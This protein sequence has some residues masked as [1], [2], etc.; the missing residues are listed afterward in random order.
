MQLLRALCDVERVVGES[1]EVVYG[2]QVFADRAVELGVELVAGYMHEICAELVLIFIYDVLGVGDKS[3]ALVAEIIN[4]T[5]GVEYVFLGFLRHGVDRQAALL[6]CKRGVVKK[7]LLESVEV[8][9]HGGILGFILDDELADLFEHGNERSQQRDD[10]KAE[11]RVHERDGHRRHARVHKGKIEDG[12]GGVENGAEDYDAEGVYHEV[13][14]RGAFAVRACA[15][16]R[17]QYGHGGADRDTHDNGQGDVKADSA[18]HGERLQNA[19]GRGCALDKAREHDAERDAEQ[20]VGEGREHFDERFARAKPVHGAAHCLHAEHQNGKAKHNFADV[21]LARIGAEHT[22]DYADDGDDRGER[23]GRK[24]L[25]PAARAGAA[26]VGKADDP[27]GDA[28]ADD[29][30]HND[31]DGLMHLHHAG[32]NEADH[33]DRGRRGRLNDRG[34]AG[35]EQ[36]ALERSAGQA[37]QNKL[38]LVARDLFQ[39]VA[40][41]RH[42]EKEQCNAA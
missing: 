30:A 2:V 15:E 36:N 18:R 35:A 5:E 4:E 27:A 41:E 37:E 29:G 13:G 11:H 10:Y 17:Q 22:Q 12:V 16:S 34:D 1:L 20:G 33:H 42:A 26:D 9:E 40:H 38:E 14:Q 19:D 28:R 32:V 3:E 21:L 8:L 6:N 31:A 23:V 24:K 39:T 25:D 7:A